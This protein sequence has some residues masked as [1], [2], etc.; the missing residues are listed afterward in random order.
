MQINI[1]IMSGLVSLNKKLIKMIKNQIKSLIIKKSR[2]KLTMKQLMGRLKFRHV[3][4]KGRIYQKV[5]S[6]QLEKVRLV[7]EKN[8]EKVSFKIRK[9]NLDSEIEIKILY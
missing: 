7:E 6:L 1:K 3:S 4:L 2:S 8:F 5:H 9:N